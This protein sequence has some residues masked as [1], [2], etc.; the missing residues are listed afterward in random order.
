MNSRRK[1]RALIIGSLAFTGSMLA[2]A[3]LISRWFWAAVGVM[4]AGY[5][6]LI[7]I[8]AIGHWLAEEENEDYYD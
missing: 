5:A 7:A 6:A 2:G 1:W 4:G 3:L 8:V